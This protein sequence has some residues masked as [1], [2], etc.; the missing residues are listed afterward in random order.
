MTRVSDKAAIRL[1]REDGP[2]SADASRAEQ[3][4]A[5]EVARASAACLRTERLEDGSVESRFALALDARVAGAGAGAEV[6]AY[7]AFILEHVFAAIEP[8]QS[9]DFVMRAGSREPG[10]SSVGL[11]VV[12][13]AAGKTESSA[14]RSAGSLHAV[15]RRLLAARPDL[16]FAEELP[17]GLALPFRHRVQFEGVLLTTEVKPAAKA[18]ELCPVVLPAISLV[19]ARVPLWEA[20]QACTFPLAI[21]VSARPVRLS[22]AALRSIVHVRANLNT[23]AIQCETIPGREWMSREQIA[24]HSDRFERDLIRWI[25]LN[26]GVELDVVLHTAERLPAGALKWLAQTILPTRRIAVLPVS[27]E[28]T[29]QD[30]ADAIDLR[31]C[32]N[33]SAPMPALLPDRATVRRLGLPRRVPMPSVKLPE[34]GIVLGDVEG[35]AVRLPGRDMDRHVYLMGATGCGKSSLLLSM[36]RQ[37]IEAGDGLALVEPHGDLHRDVLASVP[38]SRAADVIVIDPTDLGRAVGINYLEIPGLNPSIERSFV[39]NEMLKIIDRLYDLRETGG[40]MFEAYFRNALLLLME[41]DISGLTLVE[42]PL[43]FERDEFRRHLIRHCTNPGVVRFWTK[44]AER[45]RQD[46]SIEA[47]APYITS[48]LNQFGG[49]ALIRAIVGQSKSALNF[50]DVMDRRGILLVNLSK[51]VLSD[52]DSSLLGALIVSKLFLAALGRANVEREQRQPF[53]LFLDEFQHFTTDTVAGLLSESRKFGLRCVLANQYL[54]QVDVGRSAGNV[55]G[56]V[57]GNVATILAMRSGARD[58]AALEEILGGRISARTLQ[59]LPDYHVAARLLIDGRPAEPFEFTTR[60]PV[61]LPADEVA[62]LLIREAYSTRYTCE[63]AAVEQAIADRAR[64][65]SGD[66]ERDEH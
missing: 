48:K 60:K 58:A 61:S 14:E 20:L 34:S 25:C 28:S 49:N 41:S 3:D 43:I 10:A 23:P 47:L 27:A 65:G 22:A 57:L 7:D 11:R 50:R 2:G 13:A 45:A 56:A 55:L 38:R 5:G 40:P 19:E 4:S 21:C 39:C 64:L 8:G 18:S 44:Q 15:L 59:D 66:D 52:M 29:Q 37:I 32:F 53:H 12:G 36:I 46:A 17:F 6:P 33:E 24:I 62:Q 1:V 16:N 63:I 9:V 51:G 31:S 54:K 35:Q 26:T 30:L 42:M